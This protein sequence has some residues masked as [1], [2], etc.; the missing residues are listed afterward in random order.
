M[1]LGI[2]FS[3]GGIKGAA[4]IGVLKA[5]EEEKVDIDYIAGASSGSIVAVLYACGFTAD[6]I[7]LIFKEYSKNIKYIDLKNILKM[8]YN[9][10]LKGKIVI[11]GLNSGAILEEMIRNICIKKDIIKMRD[12]KKN[13]LISS[14]NMETGE[15]YMFTSKMFNK[16]Y[17]DNV[18]YINDIDVGI[19]VRASC[20]Y[21]GVFE[22]C[23][24][25]GVDLIDGGIRENTPWKQM[26][27]NGADKVI[28]VVFEEYKKI[29]KK[30]NVIDIISNS[31]NIICHELSNYELDGA[32]YILKIKTPKVQL[33]EAK[34][35]DNLYKMGYIQAK[36][37][38]KNIAEKLKKW[39]YVNQKR[40]D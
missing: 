18:I 14:V 23:K 13:I 39:E 28:C 8:L 32:D 11:R 20:S 36:K 19:A 22:P 24:Y 12:I 16:R 3:G 29:K 31:F 7:Y 38:I 37:E 35:I 4:H 33:L 15:V 1:N 10:F 5:L 40:K 30:E 26:K 21:P 9:I 25:K 27:K 2:S 17:S 6:E 34:E